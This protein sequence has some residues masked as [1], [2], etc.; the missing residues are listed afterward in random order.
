MLTVVDTRFAVPAAE[1]GDGFVPL[2]DVD[3]NNILCLK[4]ERKLGNENRV[5]YKNLRLRIPPG[6]HGRHQV[7]RTVRVHEHSDGAPVGVPR[8][9]AAGPLRGG[10][11]L[12]GRRV[13]GGPVF[14]RAAFRAAFPP[15]L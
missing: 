3:L 1:S 12:G 4:E 7:R 10:R 13:R 14:G 5:R 9:A 15:L 8:A 2:L 6:P 11:R